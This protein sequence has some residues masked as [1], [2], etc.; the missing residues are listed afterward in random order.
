MRFEKRRIHFAR[1]LHGKGAEHQVAPGNSFECPKIRAAPA[2]RL[3][4]TAEGFLKSLAR[5]ALPVMPPIPDQIFRLRHI[6]AIAELGMIADPSSE[7]FQRFLDLSDRDGYRV[8]R[9]GN[10]VP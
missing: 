2:R 1:R 5:V 10:P 6:E 4:E 9:H 7:F 8:A 3:L